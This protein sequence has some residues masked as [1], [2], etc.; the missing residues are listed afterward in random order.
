MATTFRLK[1]KLYALGFSS[2][3]RAISGLGKNGQA[4]S[5]SQRAWQAT[6]GLG[7]MAAVGGTVAAGVGAAKTATGNIGNDSY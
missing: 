5:N 2:M 4:L 3:G 6:K 1:R 7:T